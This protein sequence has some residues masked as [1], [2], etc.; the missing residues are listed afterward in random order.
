MER[1][2]LLSSCTRSLQTCL[3]L[4]RYRASVGRNAS[5]LPR[6]SS[7][8]SLHA[9]AAPA[10]AS[11]PPKSRDRGPKSS[12]DTQT[13]FAHLDVLRN[14]A[15]PATA[16]DVCTNDGFAMNN[17]MRVSGSGLLLVG[18]EAFRWKPWL[19]A[20]R[21]EATGSA[22]LTGTLV[23]EKGQWEVPHEAWGLLDLVW[24]KPGAFCSLRLLLLC[25]LQHN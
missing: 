25:Q 4:T 10:A 7:A 11:K 17:G 12:E 3:K 18:G 6:L 16:I 9:T 5:Q 2:A 20:D 21:P 14:T 22:G 19:R 13:D 1:T 24:P 23:N 8:R 15:A